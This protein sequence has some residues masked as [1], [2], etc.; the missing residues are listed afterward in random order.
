MT[1]I[2]IES[3]E[4]DLQPVDDDSTLFSDNEKI[5]VEH[6][7][8]EFV[9]INKLRGIYR[10]TTVFN[11]IHCYQ[12]IKNK[13]QRKYKYRL[14][15]AHLDPRPFRSRHIAWRWL[16]ASLG[17]FGM[18]A[19]LFFSGWLDSASVI[20]LGL[21]ICSTAVALMMLL[22]F[23]YFTHDTV[24]FRSQFGKIK[25]MEL[26]NNSPD[27]DSFRDFVNKLVMQINKSKTASNKDNG[28]LLKS[29]LQ[30]LRRLKDESVIDEQ[31]YENA[32]KLILRHDAFK[33]TG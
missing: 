14:N 24:Y 6:V 33:A 15:L 10:Q 20:A 18:D 13:H 29:E 25:L 2:N 31:V 8:F 19:A 30:Q 26:M 7:N 9:Q 27:N 23:F 28:Q 16:Y 4:I 32:K 21:F 5:P 12:S 17:L 22:A 3:A 11:D 1:E